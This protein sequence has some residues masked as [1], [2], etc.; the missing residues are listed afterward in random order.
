[1]RRHAGCERRIRGNLRGEAHSVGRTGILSSRPENGVT[2][3]CISGPDP[4]E[5]HGRGQTALQQLDGKPSPKSV[6]RVDTLAAADPAPRWKHHD[7][8][9]LILRRVSMRTSRLPKP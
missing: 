7:L 4:E 2:A 9:N 3:A 8:Q 1:K 5:R 6:R